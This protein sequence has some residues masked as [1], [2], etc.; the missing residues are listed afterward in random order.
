MAQCVMVVGC[1]PYMEY[2]G[3][4]LNVE[5]MT[6]APHVTMPT[7]IMYDIDSPGLPALEVTGEVLK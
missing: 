1:N 7:N 4:V 2:G 6:F 5:T 3:S